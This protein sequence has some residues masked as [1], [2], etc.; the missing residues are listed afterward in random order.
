MLAPPKRVFEAVFSALRQ[1][2]WVDI[3]AWNKRS[4][5]SK[6]WYPEPPRQAG[7]WGLVD[8][9]GVS[10]PVVSFLNRP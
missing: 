8:L 4:E 2:L 3:I 5:R 1:I 10:S 7:L 9:W 6:R